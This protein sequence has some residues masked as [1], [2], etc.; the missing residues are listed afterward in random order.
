MTLRLVAK[1]R[2]PI[3]SVLQMSTV[4][5]R[6]MR[7]CAPR[8]LVA[9]NQCVS[10]VFRVGWAAPRGWAA[11]RWGHGLGDGGELGIVGANLRHSHPT[12][13]R[14]VGLRCW[15]CAACEARGPLGRCICLQRA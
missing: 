15:P 3:S 4:S 5:S 12:C 10:R 1:H 6:V 13:V 8:A 7:N 2:P 11:S 9:L 14:D